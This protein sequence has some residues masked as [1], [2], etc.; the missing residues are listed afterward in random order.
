MDRFQ[1]EDPFHWP[2]PNRNETMMLQTINQ[3]DVGLMRKGGYQGT[4]YSL[5]TRDIEGNLNLSLCV[6]LF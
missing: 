3:R 2:Y 6:Y 1:R 5:A 4:N